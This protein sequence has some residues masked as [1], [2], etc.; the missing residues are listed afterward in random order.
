MNE[1]L[2]GGGEGLSDNSDG[3]EIGSSQYLGRRSVEGL[4]GKEW[5]TYTWYLESQSSGSLSLGRR[6]LSSISR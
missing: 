1:I 6:S 3:T 2:V 4:G 5:R